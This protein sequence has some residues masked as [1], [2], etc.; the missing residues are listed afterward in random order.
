MTQPQ[1]WLY[2]TIQALLGK[3]STKA[4]V[5]SVSK[6]EPWA[7]EAAAELLKSTCTRKALRAHW[8][9]QPA[10]NLFEEF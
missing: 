7:H 6:M 5:W 2:R 3:K 1:K 4:W 9:T 8:E 10:V